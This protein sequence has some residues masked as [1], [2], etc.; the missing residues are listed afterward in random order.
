MET[1]KRVLRN[2]HLTNAQEPNTPFQ[3]P[4]SPLMKSLGYGT[5]VN[6]YYLERSPRP[7]GQIRSPWA[8]KRVSKRV[9]ATNKENSKLFNERI[10]K[11]AEILRKLKHPNI[12]GFRAIKQDE[13]NGVDTLALEC[14]STSLGILLENRLEEGLSALPAQHIKKMMLDI[15]SALDYLHTEVKMLHGDLKS[16]NVLV[17]GEFEICKLCDFGVSLPLNKEGV[18]NFAENPLLHYVGTNLWS[19]PEVIS[20]EDVI[21][22]KAEIFSFGLI[23][24]E[25]IALVPPHTLSLD[26]TESDISDNED[27]DKPGNFTLMEM[28]YGTRPP[29][30]QAFELNDDYNIIVELFYL[31]TNSAPDDRPTAKIIYDSLT[32]NQE[33]E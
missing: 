15:S 8:I 29:L 6:V 26:D 13:K 25:T 1:P 33:N 23:V 30:P 18:V 20:E 24:Y 12:V 16:H 11:E 31:C 9:R 2:L 22:C 5:G 10:V 27:D 14:C 17:K 32:K 21:D 3:V 4:A 28:A 19:A 7:T